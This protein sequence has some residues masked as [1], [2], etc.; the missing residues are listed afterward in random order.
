M[1]HFC[2]YFDEHYL[3]RGLALY[4][5][6]REHCPAFRLHVLCMDRESHDALSHLGL[7]DVHL[8]PLEDL[9]RKD[10]DLL[11]A[12]KNRARIEY[13]FTCTPSLLLF[14]LDSLPEVELLTY[15]D[16]DVFFFANPTPLFEEMAGASIAIIGHRFPA[17]LRDFERFGTYNVG[18]LSFRRDHDALVCL[19]WW[20]RRCIEWCYDRC[21][22]GRFADQ[23]YL[24]DWPR[25]FPSV[26]VLRHK[27]ANLAP[28]NLANYTIRRTGGSVWVDE[29]PLIFFHFHGFKQISEWVYNPNTVIYRTRAS[30]VTR[31]S[32]FGPY[33]RT[34]LCMTRRRPPYSRTTPLLSSI[35]APMAES[36]AAHNGMALNRP[37]RRPGEFVDLCRGV[38]GRSYILAIRGYAI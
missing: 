27:G 37:V 17:S 4:H 18:W 14:V 21:E 36:P 9:E 25:R 31:R 5:S 38:L 10:T 2:T 19:N 16:A 24:D 1:R 33:I 34:L 8:I 30:S 7:P 20:R 35:R 28:W 11:G 22:N 12:K 29:A 15:V 6:L 13:Y 26:M 32:I 3:S 23:K